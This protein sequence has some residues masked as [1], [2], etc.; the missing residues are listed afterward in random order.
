MTNRVTRRPPRTFSGAAIWIDRKKPEKG[1]GLS[2]RAGALA[3][4]NRL[5]IDEQEKPEKRELSCP[6]PY[7]EYS[8][9]DGLGGPVWPL[10]ARGTPLNPWGTAHQTIFFS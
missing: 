1:R 9:H 7:F 3:L 8:C 4:G 6:G 10:G 5:K 2:R